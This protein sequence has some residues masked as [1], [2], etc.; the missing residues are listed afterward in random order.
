MTPRDGPRPFAGMGE[1]GDGVAGLGL[2]FFLP[3]ASKPLLV[4]SSDP[5]RRNARSVCIKNTELVQK[6]CPEGALGPTPDTIVAILIFLII[7]NVPGDG[8]L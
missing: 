4:Q 6:S 8:L 3:A 2:R 7:D 5:V 1:G